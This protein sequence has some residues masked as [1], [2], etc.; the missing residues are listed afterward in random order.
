LTT[1]LNEITTIPSNFVFVLD[2]YHVLDAKP[3]DQAL[4][5]LLETLRGESN[6][7]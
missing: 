2:D 1:L 4:T 6:S 7:Q 5:F 3:V